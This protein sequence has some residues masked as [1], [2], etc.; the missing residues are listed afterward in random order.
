MFR[1]VGANASIMT[2]SFVQRLAQSRASGMLAMVVP[3]YQHPNIRSCKPPGV[4]FPVY[5]HDLGPKEK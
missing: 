5:H 4:I 1:L 2:S 3:Y